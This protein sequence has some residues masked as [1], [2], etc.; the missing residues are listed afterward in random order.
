MT[1]VWEPAFARLGHNPAALEA[2][3]RWVVAAVAILALSVSTGFALVAHDIAL[4]VLGPKWLPAV[5][6]IQVLTLAAGMS[7]ITMP[8]ASVLG[9]T[10]DPRVVLGLTL[11]RTTLLVAAIVP[12]AIWLGL[13]EIA[14]GRAIAT[15]ISVVVALSVFERVVGLKQLTLARSLFRPSLAAMAMAAVV[16]ALQYAIALEP[17]LR[18]AVCIVAGG[19]TFTAAL[20]VLWVLAGRPA[21]VEHDTVALIKRRLGGMAQR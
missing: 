3:Y 8:L 5:P 9:A 16:L 6:V 13:T 20:L 12:A 7:A 1:R 2:T 15:A 14:M 4:V 19:P 17:A 18:L 10:G 21:G 11:L